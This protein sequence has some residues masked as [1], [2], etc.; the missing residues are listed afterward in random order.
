M[1]VATTN[2]TQS[3]LVAKLRARPDDLDS[4]LQLFRLCVIDGNWSRALNQLE[5]AERLDA[6]MAHT[7]MV[8]R[9]NIAAEQTRRA[10]FDGSAPPLFLGTPPAWLGYLVQALREA[11]ADAGAALANAAF[12]R[13]APVAG[14]IDDEPFAWLADADSRLGPVLEAFVDGK[15]YWIPFE[16]LGRIRIGVPDDL[17]DL[18]WCPSELTLVNGGV[19]RGYIPTRYPGTELTARDDLKLARITEWQPWSAALQK[20][21][22]QRMLVSD[23][24]EYALLDCRDIRFDAA[25]D[26]RITG[27]GS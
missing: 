12:A 26:A 24:D 11:D 27:G 21:A 2:T 17:L 1:Q 3:E 20:G 23:A 10:V 8:Y 9:C 19:C 4:R 22:G 5:V 13:A 7:A 16:H 14:A 25:A 6:A 18:A 15:Y